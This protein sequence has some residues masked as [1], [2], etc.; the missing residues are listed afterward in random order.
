M[1][2]NERM[3]P[4]FE[5]TVQATQEAILNSMLASDTMTGFQ[6][7]RVHGLPPERLVKALRKYGRLPPAP[8]PTK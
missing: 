2:D 5:A 7:V 6:S 4:L 8:K 3:T 1:L